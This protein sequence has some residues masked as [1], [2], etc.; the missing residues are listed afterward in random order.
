MTESVLN[1]RTAMLAGLA[2]SAGLAH[3]ASSAPAQAQTTQPSTLKTA[4]DRKTLRAPAVAG[5]EPYFH[6]DLTT[7]EWSGACY[8]IARSIA[9]ALQVELEV[10]E[11]TWGNQVLDLQSGKIDFC[12]MVNPTPER[13]LI[14]DF[15]RPILEPTFMAIIREGL[16][17][18]QTWADLNKPEIR[19]AVDLGSSHET[20]ARRNCPNAQILGFKTRDEALLALG[21]GRADANVAFTVLALTSVQKNPALG[22]LHVLE[23]QIKMEADLGVRIEETSRWR[24]FLN[25]WIAFNRTTGQTR[26]WF[27]GGLADIGV[28]PEMVPANVTF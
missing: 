7:G 10:V 26:E 22:K 4:L 17:P 16:P 13:G 12:T 21:S 19:I 20:L 24:D 9:E 28:T 25:A 1:R 27:M 6:K 23:P 15:T 2:G 14:M 11:T 5:A 18:V 3:L 8:E